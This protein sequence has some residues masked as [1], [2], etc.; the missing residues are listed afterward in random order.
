[1]TTT[2]YLTSRAY[3]LLVMEALKFAMEQKA[4][5]AKTR[6]KIALA[7]GSARADLAQ[8]KSKRARHKPL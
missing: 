2:Y 4:V 6:R 8:L 5:S 1:M 7:L 3:L